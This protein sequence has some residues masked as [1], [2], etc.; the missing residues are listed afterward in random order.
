LPKGDATYAPFTDEGGNLT[1]AIM[2][3]LEK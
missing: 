2:V 3:C 1:C